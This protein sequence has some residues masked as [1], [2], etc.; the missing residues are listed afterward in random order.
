M[1]QISMNTPIGT[2]LKDQ[3]LLDVVIDL[4]VFTVIGSFQAFGLRK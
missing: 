3:V 1:V 2:H 4:A